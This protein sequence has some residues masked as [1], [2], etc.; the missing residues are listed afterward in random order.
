MENKLAQPDFLKR[1]FCYSREHLIEEPSILRQS[2]QIFYKSDQLP[3]LKTQN[4]AY[5]NTNTTYIE[6]NN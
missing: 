5:E 1:C 4:A 6:S 3:K 2:H